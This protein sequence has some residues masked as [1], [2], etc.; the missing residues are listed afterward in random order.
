MENDLK[1]IFDTFEH[2]TTFLKSRPINSGHINSTYFIETKPYDA[3]NFVLQKINSYV[4]KN[5]KALIQNKVLVTEYLN[6]N[7]KSNTTQIQLIK[8]K[9]GNF[10]CTDADNNYWNLMIYIPESKV[11]LK[12]NKLKLA[13]EAGKLFGKFFFDLKDFKTENL[14]ITIPN[15][16]D[17]EYRFLEFITAKNQAEC[18]RIISAEQY[19]NQIYSH[20]DEMRILH[21]LKINGEVPLR[22]THNDTKLSNALF[23]KNSN[24]L[25]VIDLDTLMPGLVHYDFGDSIRTICSSADEDEADLSKVHFR[26]NY[27]KAFATSFISQCGPILTQKE[28][29]HFVLASKY[30]VFIMAMRFLTDFLNKDLYYKINF[31]THNLIRAKNQFALLQSM[32]RQ[33]SEMQRIIDDIQIN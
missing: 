1:A 23:D 3:S 5:I 10:Y 28:L 26:L 17:I 33:Q 24:A 19:I 16:H 11:Y 6:N 29:Q 15:F 8:S 27:F 18:E 30:M 13:A 20:I 7:S 32:N 9:S 22:V 4:F 21:R 2:N 14:S 31:P 12:A 25:A